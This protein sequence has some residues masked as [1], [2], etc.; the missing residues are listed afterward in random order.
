MYVP[1]RVNPE[2]PVIGA[3][4]GVLKVEQVAAPDLADRFARMAREKGVPC[5]RLAFELT[6]SRSPRGTDGVPLLIRQLFAAGAAITVD[7]FGAGHSNLTRILGGGREAGP[8][9]DAHLPYPGPEA[10]DGLSA[11]LLLRHAHGCRRAAPVSA[12]RSA[13]SV[14]LPLFCPAFR[15]AKRG[16]IL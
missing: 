3:V 11:G 13:L 6:E 12:S 14:H 1:V 10:G 5:S 8:L 7:G 15:V 4:L 9:C 16:K 2:Q